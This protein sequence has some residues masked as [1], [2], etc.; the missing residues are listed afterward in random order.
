[1]N[2]HVLEYNG[3]STIVSIG[4]NRGRWAF[5]RPLRNRDGKERWGLML[6]ALPPGF[7]DKVPVKDLPLTEFLQAGGSAEAMSLQIKKPGGQQ[8]GADYVKYA[9]GHP[10]PDEEKPAVDV[11]IE[12][13]QETLHV[14]TFE[15]FNAEEAAD[16]FY[17]YYATGDI[18]HDYTLRPLEAYTADRRIIDIPS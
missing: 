4:S 3:G 16:L 18:P 11:E 10:H 12:L 15:V 2:T 5:D 14:T 13:P 8:W 9:V 6:W 7:D 17:A 1:M